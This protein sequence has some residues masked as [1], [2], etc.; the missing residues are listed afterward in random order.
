MEG[1][2]VVAGDVLGDVRTLST[3]AGAGLRLGHGVAQYGRELRA[4][5]SGFLRRAGPRVW[6][7]S[8]GRR[9][10]PC[11][12]DFVVGVVLER[13]SEFSRVDIGGARDA[14]LPNEAFEGVS[15]KNRPDVFVGALVYARVVVAHRDMD[16]EISCVAASGHADGFGTLAAGIM[17]A[18]STGMAR[19]LL[20]DDGEILPALAKRGPFEAAVG[21]N[22]RVWLRA[23]TPATALALAHTLT[24][25]DG[26]NRS[27]TRAF[28][29]DSVRL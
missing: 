23:A 10:A 6:V 13:G 16:P 9:Y 8:S 27:E 24:S 25:C 5:D 17:F 7:E 1:E 15:R 3:V 19:R 26:L 22:G 28:L 2:I 29:D 18:V 14:T 12:D 11:V 21:H 20:D 4:T